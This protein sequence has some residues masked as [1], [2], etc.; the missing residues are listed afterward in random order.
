LALVSQFGRTTV[1]E[2]VEAQP[3]A[4]GTQYLTS[5]PKKPKRKRKNFQNNALAMARAYSP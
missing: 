1:A 3:K 4:G 5:R 2:L